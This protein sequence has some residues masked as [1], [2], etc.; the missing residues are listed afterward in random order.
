M[1]EIVIK[2]YRYFHNHRP[3]FWGTM[4]FLFV[5]FGYFASRIHLEEDLNKLMPSSRNADGSTKL[6]FAD[7][8][9]KDKT[10]LLFEG[11][12]GMSPD[13]IAAAADAF[14]D[15]LTALDNRQP[16]EQRVI[17]DIFY[18]MPEDAMDGA[19]SYMEEHFP[20]YIDT[21]VY[22][23]MDSLL[24]PEHF[25]QQMV[26]NSEDMDGD[27]GSAYPELIQMDPMG[28]RNLL[29]KQMKPLFAGS[30]GGYKTIAGH[31]FVP[32][33]SVCIAFITPRFSATDTGQ[34]N[35]LFEMLNG[36]IKSF[37]KTHPNVSVCYHGTP[38][39]G[40]YNS[41]TIKRDLTTTLLGAFIIVLAFIFICFRNWDTLPLLILP[42]VFGTLFGL[43]MMY[44]IE[45]QFSLLALG[46]GAVVLGVAMSYVLHV[47]THY[48]YI[49]D[50]EQVLRDETKPVF[51]GCL[52]TIG[53]FMG[54]I[55]VNTDLLKDFGLFAAFAIVGTTFFSL[56]FLPQLLDTK[57]N[58]INKKAFALID[59][60]NNYPFDRKKPL[61][62]VICAIT[63]VC[64]G[65]WAVKGTN[66]D[67]DL[68]NLGY[69]SPEVVHSENLLASKTASGIGSKYFASTGT[70]MEEALGHFSQLETKLDSLQRLGLVK[71]YTPTNLILVPEATQKVRIAAWKRYWTPARLA[72]MRSLIAATAP[73]AGFTADA[74]DPFFEAVEANYKPDKL[75]AAGIIPPGY[76]ST[77]MEKTYDGKYL[78]FTSVK[79]DK[80]TERVK[81]GA[82]DRITRAIGDE[83]NMMVLDTSYYTQDTLAK[84]NSDFNIL[85]WVSM[86]FVFIVLL[87]SF[88]WNIKYTL[89]GFMPIILSWLIVL[90][91]MDIFGLKFN[92]LNIIIS[93]FIFGIGVDY[94][95]FVMNGLIDD[96]A[97]GRL[98]QLH[99]SAIF[100]SAFIL[101]VTVSSMLIARHPAIQS[102][103]FST[104]VGLLSAVIL[105][106]VLQPAIFRKL[107]K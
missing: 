7:L 63:V 54:L 93:T 81:G 29:M 87:V 12:K 32:D 14:I 48:K 50:P 74:F 1:T 21:T 73:S 61:I 66:F 13:S 6:A 89:L 52:T 9:I 98:L 39:S 19:I 49:T 78:C 43:A 47:L 35:R 97:N 57:K 80:A 79:Y 58:R 40:Y 71:G 37:A 27:F 60:I 31:F 91:A 102:V 5:F 25:K 53:S 101:V 85:Q 77:L 30:Q 51:L 67:T 28:M 94:S 34:G 46:I 92:L 38:A 99:K 23:Q 106:Y 95:I 75:Y 18:Q 107:K 16:K 103:G 4:I 41:T 88:R 90:G 2:I 24:T 105:S 83:P 33:G 96:K 8:R 22:A 65:F 45:G 55:F 82:Y 86:A 70:T 17:S 84:L 69:R 64:I 42:V 62:A 26:K 10:Y 104:L 11:K 76:L 100:F 36:Q 3:V 15:S 20:A 44:F 72:K 56:I 68:N 59:R